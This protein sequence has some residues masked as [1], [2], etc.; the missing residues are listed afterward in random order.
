MKYAAIIRYTTGEH[1]GATVE[2]ESQGEAWFKL[3]STI[4]TDH[5]S[6]VEIAEILTPDREIQ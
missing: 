6:A 5:V 2:A 3:M 1:T 4:N